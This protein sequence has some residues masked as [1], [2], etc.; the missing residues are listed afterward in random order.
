V[1][2]EPAKKE[3]NEYFR[4]WGKALLLELRSKLSFSQEALN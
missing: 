2:A 1:L 4:S 3:K